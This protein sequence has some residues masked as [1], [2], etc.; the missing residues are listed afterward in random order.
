MSIVCDHYRTRLQASS[1][2]NHICILAFGK[3]RL[4]SHQRLSAWIN[5]EN[6]VTH[7][8]IKVVQSQKFVNILFI[9]MKKFVVTVQLSI[10]KKDCE[11]EI[12]TPCPAALYC[13]NYQV[14]IEDETRTS[15]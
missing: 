8:N 9:L 13:S 5:Y 12:C 1:S 7:K 11:D 3:I 10:A 2:V 4:A 6:S 14:V 15:S